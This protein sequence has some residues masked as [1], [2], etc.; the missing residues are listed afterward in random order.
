MEDLQSLFIDLHLVDHPATGCFFMW[1]NRRTKNFQWRKLDRIVVNE[2]WLISRA[3]LKLPSKSQEFPTILPSFLKFLVWIILVQNPSNTL[4]TRAST[5]T[6]LDL[7]EKFGL[8]LLVAL[9][10]VLCFQDLQF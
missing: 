4:I 3:S 1:S 9:L 2:A 5:K 8:F 6:S 7:Y 10:C